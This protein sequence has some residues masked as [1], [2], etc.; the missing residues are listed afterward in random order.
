[1]D[2]MNISLLMNTTKCSKKDSKSDNSI[3]AYNEILRLIRKVTNRQQQAQLCKLMLEQCCSKELTIV[4]LN[5]I[6]CAI[7]KI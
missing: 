7:K 2:E 4:Q 3:E 5:T 6:F 1:M